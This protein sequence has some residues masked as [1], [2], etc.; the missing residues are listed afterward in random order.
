M[1]RIASESARMASSS[2]PPAALADA[3]DAVGT[4][5]FTVD[6][7]RPGVGMPLTER[8]PPGVGMPL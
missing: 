5:V 8:A 1:A 7:E 4:G 2:A 3:E 6:R